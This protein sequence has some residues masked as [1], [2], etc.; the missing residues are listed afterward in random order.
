MKKIIKVPKRKQ[1]R[2]QQ[3]AKKPQKNNNISWKRLKK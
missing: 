3:M 1:G 2:Q